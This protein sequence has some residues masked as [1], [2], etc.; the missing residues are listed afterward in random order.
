MDF[1]DLYNRYKTLVIFKSLITDDEV[2]CSF[3]DVIDAIAWKESD[4]A[5][6]YYSNFIFRLYN[7][8]DDFTEYL[9]NAVLE[10]ENIYIKKKG[11][12]V[13]TGELLDEC[14]EN[15]LML[16]EEI[17]QISYDAL[18]EQIDF[19]DFLPRYK[20]HK[21]D[22][23]KIYHER[24]ENVSHFGYGIYSRYHVFIIKE[25]DMDSEIVGVEH[26]DS[27]S[28][29]QLYGYERERGEVIDN[30]LALL[31]G[32][33][34]NNVLLYGD[35]GTGKS[36]TVKAIANEYAGD[37]LR[38]IEIKKKQLHKIPD[39]VKQISCN[40]LK[41]ILF[42]DDLSFTEDDEDFAA[43][44]A[45]LEGSVASSADNLCIYATSN[46]RHLIRETFSARKGDEI[47]LNDT[48]QELLS[49]SDRFGLTVTY[50]KPD[51]QLYLSVAHDLA[52]QYDVKLNE[53]ELKRQA[54]A[55][56][57]SRGGRSPR[58]AKQFIEYLKGMEKD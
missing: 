30:T 21:A 53:E 57:L 56:A 9:L 12:G 18:R 45:I 23:R 47:H 52:K 46:R 44:K 20:T 28:L 51:K 50:T 38:L 25:Y 3:T 2:L 36:S 37:G 26:P 5:V 15:E 58:T 54:E 11:E 22:F 35:C 8:G 7:Y 48:M 41:F 42:I 31:S 40:P 6:E 32:K 19:Y 55:F 29:S 24:I 14:L 39:I 1:N 10:N 4:C 33:P 17:S 13:K 27:I 43:L 16:L 49:L 34:A